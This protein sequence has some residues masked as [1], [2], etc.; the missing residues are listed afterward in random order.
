MRACANVIAMGA[1]ALGSKP[2]E[3]NWEPVREY[4]TEDDV[5]HRPEV[6]V[7]RGSRLMASQSPKIRDI[8]T[9]VELVAPTSATVLLLGETGA[10]KEVFA[11]AIHELSPRHQRQMIR[12][13]CAA[14]PSTLIESE[15]FGCE[16]GAFTDAITRRIGRFEAASQSTLFLD[17]IGE[18]VEAEHI[19][20]TLESTK[21]RIRG[22]G[23]AA[24]RLAL[25]PTTLESRLLKLGIE[26]PQPSPHESRRL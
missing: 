13:S 18:Q 12:V 9:Q 2:L 26:R 8:L 21:W 1:L 15:L 3:H 11:E 20:A 6:G 24:E 7:A 23:G 16:R 10:G 25:K 22:Q 19:R 5:L 17:E 4:T 14:I